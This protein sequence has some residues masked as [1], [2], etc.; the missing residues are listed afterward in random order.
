MTHN[1]RC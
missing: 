1:V